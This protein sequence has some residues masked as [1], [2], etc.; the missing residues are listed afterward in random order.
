[1]SY[2]GSK[3][4]NKPVVASD[5]D[6][7]VITGQ[8]ALATSPADTDE[9]LISDAGVLKRLDASLIGGTNTP[10]FLAYKTSAQSIAN[11][12]A[13]QVTFDTE[14][15]DSDGK[16][17]S[18]RFTPTVAGKYFIYAQLNMQATDGKYFETRI[19][20]NGSI[21]SY[22]QTHMGTVTYNAGSYIGEVIDSDDNDYFEIFTYHNSGASKNL[23]GDNRN[24]YFGAYKII[25]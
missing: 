1:M 18:N 8:T 13:V 15:Y 7:T 19:H 4:A 21:I 3:P 23:A 11:E 5:L 16:F 12:T 2:I 14:L 20:K 6:P 25:E 22:T 10:S 9:F 17:A 24:S